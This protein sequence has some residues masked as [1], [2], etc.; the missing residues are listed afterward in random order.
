MANLTNLNNKFLVTTGGNVGIN[1]TSPGEKLEVN[2]N[3]QGLDTL[4]LKNSSSG[5]K[6]QFYRDGN[7]T[8][9]FR[10]NN[11]SS[12]SANAISI[13]NNNNVGIGTYE[14]ATKLQ[15]ANAGEVIVRS[16]MTAADGYRGGF[17]AD[18]QHTGG[19]IWSMFS[20]NN[21]DGYFGGGKYVIANESMGGVD[22][23]TTAKFVI[24]GSGNVGIG[25]TSPEGRLM[26]ETTGADAT[27]PIKI[28]RGRDGGRIQMQYA[29][30]ENGYGEIGQMYAGTGRTQI[31]IGANL[32]SF[33][34]GHSSAPVQDDANYASWFS[35][36][37]SYNDRFT[38]NRISSGTTSQIFTISS[39]ENVGIGTT[40][41]NK[42]LT[43]YGG[44]D[45]GIWVDSSGAQYTSVAWGN[46]GSEK[47]NIAYDNTN[48][49]F[50]LTAYGAS[51]TLFSNNGS[52]RM[53][54]HSDGNVTIGNTTSVQPLTVAGNVLFRTTTADSFE[55]RFQFIVGGS[56]DAG[57][58]YVYN[59]A[60]TATVRL[61]GNGN[62]YLNGGNVGI[63]T[64]TPNEKLVVGTTSGTQ[65]IEISNSFIQSFNRSGSPGY[66]ALG[67][68]ASSYTF[69]V[70]SVDIHATTGDSLLQ[71]NIDGDTYS[72]GIDNSDS[73]KFK[74]SYGVFS[75]S[76]ILTLDTSLNATFAGNVG[77]GGAP[78]QNLDIQ[79]SGA[80]FRL[81]DG[82]NQFNMGLWDGSN[83]RFEGDANRPIYMTSYEGNIN[84][85]ISGGTTM[86][87]KSTQVGI[88]TTTP[89]TTLEV[90]GASSAFNAHFG[91]GTDNQSGVFGG[92]S[93]GY[94]EA[95]TSYRKVG[96]VAKAI[97]DGAA[98]QDLH[99]LVDTVSDSGSA[100]IA[101][102]KMSIAATTGYVTINERLG[103]GTTSPSGDVD[104]AGPYLFLG[105][106]NANNG[107]TYLT[108][109]NYDSTLVDEGDVPN[110][111]RMT[112]RYWSGATSQL[113]ETRITHIKDSSDGNGGSALGF[114]TQTGG[115]SPVE[116]M[117]IDKDG[118][119][120]IGRTDP[121]ARLDIKGVGGGNGLTFET[122]DSSNNQT[123]FIRDGGGAG[124]RYYPFSIG[125]TSAETIPTSNGLAIKHGTPTIHLTDSSSSGT[126]SLKLDGVNTT[127]QNFSTNGHISLITNGSGNVGIGKTNPSTQLDV[128]GVITCGDSTTDGA[129]RRQHQTF[130]TM[131]PGP[132]SGGNVDMMFV[133]HTHTLDVTVMAYI[134]TS[135]VA[136]AR[137]Y[138]SAA[139]GS[140][141]AGFTQTNFSPNG[142]ISAISLSYVNSGGS[143]AYILRVNVTYS[144]ATA[145]VISMTANGQSTSELRAA[146]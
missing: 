117:R 70:G 42:K 102:S 21:S 131:K 49:N 99:F 23:N 93:L 123:F 95:N 141:S 67:F 63:G 32:D 39:T 12:W 27:P 130:A 128:Q 108:L 37:D 78:G 84:F 13:K 5:V 17:E 64:T 55:N 98:R 10:Y 59:A 109:R 25:T 110:M 113:V 71:F 36:W 40:S 134:N 111:F 66:A 87:I 86:T 83:Y 50:A 81:I 65:N 58:F 6:W 133:D 138:S 135:T 145:P 144:G 74:I 4:L 29:G 124:L 19:T 52:E 116:H 69:N 76:D 15:V 53:R 136:V 118:N 33:S 60:E 115:D 73:D 20:T 26:V 139:Y 96:I 34:T 38:I 57:N 41:P 126:L 120:G 112:S 90:D 146:T 94:S 1:S 119:V 103:V 48:A 68:Y 114:M 44:N 105:T 143:E 107:T 47:A 92:I 80:R 91:Q 9:N 61:N 56:G 22:A 51:N 77:I 54:I 104:I 140:A 129:I 142:T 132:S 16:S 121:N 97:A 82:T 7:E 8:L 18:N 43:V 106:E 2:G 75:N 14:P 31:W 88:G 35:T 72:M 45:N 125:Y 30:N 11:G 89:Q 85:G 100:G 137:G 127:L 62:S 3:I 24:D 28:N 101:D 79:K 122:S 46:N